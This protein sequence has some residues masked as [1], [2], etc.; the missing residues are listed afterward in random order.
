[1]RG[2]LFSRPVGAQTWEGSA[3]AADFDGWGLAI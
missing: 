2:N 1:M 3:T